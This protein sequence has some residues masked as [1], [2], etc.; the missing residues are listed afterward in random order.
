MQSSDKNL[1]NTLTLVL[2]VFGSYGAFAEEDRAKGLVRQFIIDNH[3]VLK[4]KT[5]G[6]TYISPEQINL[7]LFKAQQFGRNLG[8]EI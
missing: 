8:Q 7:T 2:L 1:K 3:P 5:G 6:T 4:D